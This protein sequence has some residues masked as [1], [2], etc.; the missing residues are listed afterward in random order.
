V[1]RATAEATALGMTNQG[2]KQFA[3]NYANTHK[4]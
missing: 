4:R 2:L 3:L 1:D